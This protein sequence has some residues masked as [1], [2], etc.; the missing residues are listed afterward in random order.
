MD[1]QRSDPEIQAI[2]LQLELDQLCEGHYCR[3]R[4]TEIIESGKMLKI[5]ETDKESELEGNISV[6][7]G[8]K[9]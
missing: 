5:V 9:G 4:K 3:E 1:V 7:F 6:S 2:K 8:G